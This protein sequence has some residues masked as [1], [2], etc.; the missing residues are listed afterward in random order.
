MKPSIILAFLGIICLFE[1]CSEKTDFDEDKA[2]KE[3]YELHNAQRKYHFEK[4]SISYVNQ[5]SSNYIEVKKGKITRPRLEEKLGRYHSYFSQVEFLKWD[6]L[7]EP[8]IRFSEDGSLAYTIVDKIVEVS[9]KDENG[10]ETIGQTHF[11]W[12]AIYRKT[13]EGWKVECAISTNEPI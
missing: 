7:Q 8:I 2:R 6:D 3:I 10:E 9:Y 4:D 11:A 5:L 13:K 1:S 12:T